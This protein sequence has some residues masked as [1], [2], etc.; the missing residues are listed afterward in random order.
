MFEFIKKLLKKEKE[1]IEEIK[2]EEI[3]PWFKEKVK[4]IE[5]NVKEK[6]EDIRK[7]LYDKVEETKKTVEELENSELHNSNISVRELQFMKGNRKSYIHSTRMFLREIEDTFEQEMNFFLTHYYEYLDNFVKST[8]RAYR[9]LQEF[10][11]N[12]ASE[13]AKK[14]KEIDRVVDRIK[15]DKEMHEQSIIE[16]NNQEL[17]SIN[18][19]IIKKNELTKEIKE[20]E[21]KIKGIEKDIKNNKSRKEEIVNTEEYKDLK[22]KEQR[23]E[24]IEKEIKTIKNKL[25]NNFSP[26]ERALRKYS[27]IS[28]GDEKLIEHYYSD[29]YKALKT[30]KGLKIINILEGLKNNIEKGKIDLKDKKSKKAIET[31]EKMSKYFFEKIIEEEEIKQKEKKEIRNEI[32]ESKIKEEYEEVIEKIEESE[33]EK[34]RK[35][36]RL[37]IMREEQGSID[38]THLR[39]KIKKDIERILKIKIKFI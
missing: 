16:R 28:L 14:I 33:K 9:I 34:T 30:D 18:H 17:E 21:A 38:I 25:Y 11:A 31:I 22:K 7:E 27:K 10:F 26:I 4:T 39:N 23:L 19:K 2:E 32:E 3:E 15:A 29:A 35:D 1:I 24:E 13:V 37:I 5:K 36:K 8:S 12:E 6:L 20:I